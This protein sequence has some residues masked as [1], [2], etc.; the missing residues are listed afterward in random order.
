MEEFKK[1]VLDF[2]EISGPKI[3]LS[4]I[5]LVVGLIIIKLLMGVVKKIL[6]KSKLDPICHKFVRSLL[7][8]TLYIL[9]III[10]LS[11]LGVDMTSLVAMLGVAGLAVGLAVQ[12]SLANLAGGFILLFTKPFKVGDFIEI[13][14][15]SGTVKHINILQTKLNTIDNKAIFIPN[16]Q[17]SS[18][19]IINYSAEPLR[20]LDLTFSIGYSDDVTKAKT[21]L[22]EIID[23]NEYVIKD[24]EPVIRMSEHSESSIKII[25][26]VWVN[27]EHYWDLN[28]DLLEQ[29]KQSFDSNNI[30]IPF[31]QLDI[32]IKSLEEALNAKLNSKKDG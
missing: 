14:G 10:A 28:Y 1:K 25:A 24:P 11:T 7:Q 5:I 4:I 32:N 31:R 30:S 27:T 23:K 6:K 16:G 29:V 9:I 8:I 15:I 3:L 17:V 19:K 21:L 2:L 20:R 12:D 22:S 13:A 26:K 18:A